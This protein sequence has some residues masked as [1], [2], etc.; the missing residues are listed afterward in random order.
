VRERPKACTTTT[1][2]HQAF[3]FLATHSMLLRQ[4]N[5]HNFRQFTATFFKLKRARSPSLQFR[6]T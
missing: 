6:D 4:H 2:Q 5:H 1:A 3:E